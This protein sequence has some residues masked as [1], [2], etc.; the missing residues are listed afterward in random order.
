ME[1]ADNTV[2]ECAQCCT[3]A[4]RKG[5]GGNSNRAGG[6]K[7][8]TKCCTSCQN[9]PA[10]VCYATAVLVFGTHPPFLFIVLCFPSA[11]TLS[12]PMGRGIAARPA[13]P[14]VRVEAAAM[15]ARGMKPIQVASRAKTGIVLPSRFWSSFKLFNKT[16]K[17]QYPNMDTVHDCNVAYA[18][19]L[20]VDQETC[21]EKGL[22]G[23]QDFGNY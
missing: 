16:L 18:A 6:I 3:W 10:S 17:Y 20:V 1:A 22:H 23:P 2:G 12:T 13:T 9:C 8:I 15:L 7:T 4:R 19:S 5:V 14:A 21:W 11:S